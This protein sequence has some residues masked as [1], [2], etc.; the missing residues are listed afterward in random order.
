M[1]LRTT[2]VFLIS[3]AALFGQSESTN[4][5]DLVIRENR[6]ELPF[7]DKSRTL[8]ILTREE[9]KALPVHSIAEALQ[10]VSGLDIRP[11]GAFGVQADVHVRGGGF[12][13]VLVLINGVRLSDPQTGHHLLNLPIPWNS[14][15]RIEI[16][17][18]PGARIYGQNAFTAAINIVTNV[19]DDPSLEVG[20]TTGSFDYNR[21]NASVSI[22]IKNVKQQLSFERE[23]SA[24]YRYNTDYKLMNLF[25]QMKW[26]NSQK[27]E[28][29]ITA[30][31]SNRKFGANGFYAS[32]AFEDQYEEVQ[33]NVVSLDYRVQKGQVLIKPR[34]FW[35]RNQ[36]R[37][38]FLRNDPAVYQNF[39]LSQVG[40]AEM[41]LS[42]FNAL[43][44][45]GFGVGYDQ[46][47]LFSSR[48]GT[49][50][51]GTSNLFVEHR[52]QFFNAKMDLIPGCAVSNYS[53]FGWFAYPGIDLG[54]R[55]NSTFKVYVNAGYTYRIP[56]YTD[57]YYEDAGNIGNP[58]LQPEEAISSELGMSYT[59]RGLQLNAAAFVRNGK[60]LIDWGRDN[61][62]EK[63]S[64]YNFNV[65][66]TR[67][68][69][70][71]LGFPFSRNKGNLNLGYT[72]L[73]ATIGQTQLA[74]SKYQLN[75]LKHQLTGSV[76]Y[77][78]LGPL[79]SSLRVRWNDRYLG[80]KTSTADYTV[81]DGKL[82]LK[83]GGLSVF[84]NVN[85]LFDTTYGD[86]R[87]DQDEVLIQ[88]G[89]WFQFGGAINLQTSK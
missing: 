10:S 2:L 39:H 46:T 87:Y 48:L 12:D 75:Q 86:I 82:D 9:L 74:Y 28:W 6:L 57:L 37:Y 13:Q 65:V 35:R 19:P 66:E 60:N 73:D 33:T 38:I 29:R 62:Q 22:P 89:R 45:T 7:S 5:P 25:Y 11:R 77:R 79:W 32:L 3:A 88:P 59:L 1:K 41:N 71:S 72:W 34:V 50:T 14:I 52:F 21:V 8:E 84:L 55:F 49:R 64:T 42:W 23:R 43:G 80:N 67:G 17:K 31:L 47:G 26:G 53:D 15:E 24:G 40:G 4:L 27:G 70:V 85:N 54:W 36:D 30:G 69:D 44:Q 68:F 16:L 83:L 63:W 61:P 58:N 56:T 18:G 78:I 20:L 81:V 76:R 51:R